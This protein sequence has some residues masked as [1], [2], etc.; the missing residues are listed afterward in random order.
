M[1]SLSHASHGAKSK[2]SQEA[3]PP[4]DNH[5]REQP[6][7]TE[8]DWLC[9]PLRPRHPARLIPITSRELSYNVCNMRL[10]KIEKLKKECAFW[11]MVTRI[12]RT[13]ALVAV[14]R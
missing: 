12:A 3:L 1:N 8:R 7:T 9:R 11:G 6:Q 14:L 13:S 10:M 4:V 2:G 5:E